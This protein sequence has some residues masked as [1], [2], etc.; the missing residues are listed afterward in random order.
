[1]VGD[2]HNYAVSNVIHCREHRTTDYYKEWYY[3]PV[4]H[5]HTNISRQMS[6]FDVD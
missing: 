5:K 4:S 1:M 6:I 3:F 2:P